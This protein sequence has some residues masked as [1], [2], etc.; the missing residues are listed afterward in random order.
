MLRVFMLLGTRQSAV[1]EQGSVAS[2]QGGR[3]FRDAVMLAAPA[4]RHHQDVETA[5][6]FAYRL[7]YSACA[8]RITYGENLESLRPL[9][10]DTFAAELSRAVA[11][12]LLEPGQIG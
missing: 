7:T 2:A 11:S 9:D 10:W 6:D 3:T 4:I 12:Y 8:H 5:I 1:F